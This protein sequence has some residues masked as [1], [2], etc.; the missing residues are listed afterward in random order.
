MAVEAE[1][2]N[3]AHRAAEVLGPV[4]GIGDLAVDEL[5]TPYPLADPVR[6]EV[7]AVQLGD[8]VAPVHESPGDGQTLLVGVGQDR[9]R[10]VVRITVGQMEAPGPLHV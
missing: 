3:G 8:L 10:V 9:R 1:A 4:R 2:G 7:G 6:V 5:E